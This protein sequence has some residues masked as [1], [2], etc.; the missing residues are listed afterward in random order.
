MQYT[1]EVESVCEKETFLLF[2]CF[3][4]DIKNNHKWV[5]YTKSK[6]PKKQRDI[7]QETALI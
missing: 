7:A 2:S 6:R 1:E 4:M 5:S 3:F